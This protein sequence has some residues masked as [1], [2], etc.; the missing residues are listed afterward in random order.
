[1]SVSLSLSLRY[2]VASSKDGPL[3]SSTLRG[4]LESLA[5]RTSTP[6]GGSASAVAA[7]MVST[8]C[9]DMY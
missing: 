2:R 5:A 6:G 9:P 3:L 4:F 7:S 8:A 1:M